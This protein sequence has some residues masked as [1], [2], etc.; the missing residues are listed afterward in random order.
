MTA[1]VSWNLIAK[2]VFDLLQFSYYFLPCL[3]LFLSVLTDS[4][5]AAAEAIKNRVSIFY[6][7]KMTLVN[8]TGRC[9]GTK[10]LYNTA[11]VNLVT[12]YI[13][14]TVGCV[15]TQSPRHPREVAVRGVWL[16]PRPETWE[17]RAVFSKWCSFVSPS[18]LSWPDAASY[19]LTRILL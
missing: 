19:Q 15:Y 16:A 3:V 2:V 14:F 13:D 8:H 9:P 5:Y 1:A 7:K 17:V 4:L 18:S 10:A 12:L 11:T 6:F